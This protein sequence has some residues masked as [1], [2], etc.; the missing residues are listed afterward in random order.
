ML[1]IWQR[2]GVFM[3]DTD[4]VL[5]KKGCVSIFVGTAEDKGKGDSVENLLQRRTI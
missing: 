5:A 3:A 2:L 4:S 1:I